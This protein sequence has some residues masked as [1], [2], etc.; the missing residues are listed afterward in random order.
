MESNNTI[1]QCIQRMI[2]AHTNINTRMMYRTSLAY[3]NIS[4]FRH[5][6][7]KKLHT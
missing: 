7:T 5:L 6:A 2:L 4:R 3:D 1:N